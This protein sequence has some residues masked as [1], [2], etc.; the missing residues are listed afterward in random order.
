MY[1]YPQF[2]ILKNCAR[3]LVL[4]QPSARGIATKNLGF[5]MAKDA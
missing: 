1:F 3:I 5:L 2:L 4:H